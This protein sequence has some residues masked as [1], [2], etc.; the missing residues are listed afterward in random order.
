MSPT[1]GGPPRWE[2]HACM[3]S[4]EHL[5]PLHWSLPLRSTTPQLTSFSIVRQAAD[6]LNA[7]IEIETRYGVLDLPLTFHPKVGTAPLLR[8]LTPLL[9][10]PAQSSNHC[11]ACSH[12]FFFFPLLAVRITANSFDNFLYR[13]GN[14]SMEKKLSSRRCIVRWVHISFLPFPNKICWN[15]ELLLPIIFSPPFLPLCLHKNTHT[16]IHTRKVDCIHHFY[17]YLSRSLQQYSIK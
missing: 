13:C 9:A 12:C 4:E 17:W 5:L 2:G 8:S 11:N 1:S 6:A 14:G 16:Y 10:T 3:W 15:H 7:I